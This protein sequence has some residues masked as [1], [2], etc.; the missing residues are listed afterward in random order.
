MGP[1]DAAREGLEE[2]H[3]DHR[4]RRQVGD[5][6]CCFLPRGSWKVTRNAR[7]ERSLCLHHSG[8]I[9]SV[10]WSEIAPNPHSRPLRSAREEEKEPEVE[11]RDDD[12]GIHEEDEDDAGPSILAKISSVGVNLV[13]S[14]TFYG[15]R[16]RLVV[17][18]NFD[19]TSCRVSFSDFAV[20][21]TTSFR[22]ILHF[23]E[24]AVMLVQCFHSP[25]I[26]AS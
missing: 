18:P 12:D 17:G 19:L 25:S 15:V 23:F 24:A 21:Q 3:R 4:F 9:A 7:R 1:A 20:D 8:C 2:V 22:W 11:Q 13:A 10:H 16:L 14:G 6:C 5:F 26:V